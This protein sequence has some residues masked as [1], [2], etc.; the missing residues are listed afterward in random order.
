MFYSVFVLMLCFVDPVWHCGYL[1]SEAGA[2]YIVLYNSGP[3]DP[4]YV[5]PLQSV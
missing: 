5:M 2:G 1:V 3:A 4:G